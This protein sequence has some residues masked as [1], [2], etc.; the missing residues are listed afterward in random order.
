MDRGVQPGTLLYEEEKYEDPFLEIFAFDDYDPDGTFDYTF[1]VYQSV[2][3]P[4]PATW[5]LL[6]LGFATAGAALRHRP[7]VVAP[8]KRRSRG[9]TRP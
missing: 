7:R 3:V 2:A 8:V 9:Q 6:I 4:E 5:A 1:T